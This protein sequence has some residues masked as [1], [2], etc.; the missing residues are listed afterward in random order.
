MSRA[1]ATSRRARGVPPNLELA[2]AGAGTTRVVIGA[3]RLF[4]D[5]FVLDRSAAAILRSFKEAIFA[6][7][8][9]L[10]DHCLIVMRIAL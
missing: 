5:H 7:G 2:L 10:S 1:Q 8:E 6:G 9:P 4:I 3:S